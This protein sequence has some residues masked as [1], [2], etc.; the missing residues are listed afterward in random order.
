LILERTFRAD[1]GRALHVAA[2]LL[3]H[4]P[5]TCSEYHGE[6]NYRTDQFT[7]TAS[8]AY[9]EAKPYFSMESNVAGSLTE[10][11]TPLLALAVL[12]H[13]LGLI[14]IAGAIAMLF[15]PFY[16]RW[17]LGLLRHTWFNF[18]LLWALALMIAGV[19]ALMV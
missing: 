16:E 11:A 4:K 5:V 14:V 17:G 13:T 10:I 7:T 3:K 6:P 18:D 19:T 12:V 2:A 9:F 8:Y 1:P 15:Y